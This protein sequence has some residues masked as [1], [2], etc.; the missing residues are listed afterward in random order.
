[1]RV[2]NKDTKL[3][4]VS[5]DLLE[6]NGVPAGTLPIWI[7]PAGEYKGF[8]TWRAQRAREPGFGA[9]PHLERSVS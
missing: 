8:H 3:S 2:C 7:P 6:A 9:E 5:A 1:M 4:W